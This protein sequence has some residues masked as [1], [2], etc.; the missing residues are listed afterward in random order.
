MD[1]NHQSLVKSGTMES[2]YEKIA[3]IVLKTVEKKWTPTEQEMW[4]QAFVKEARE[5]LGTLRLMNM[6]KKELHPAIVKACRQLHLPQED[7]TGSPTFKP[8]YFAVY[9]E[10]EFVCRPIRTHAEVKKY[11]KKL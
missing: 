2:S 4:K 6:T 8:C 9:D 11:L 7:I 1:K 10:H 5:N 3:K